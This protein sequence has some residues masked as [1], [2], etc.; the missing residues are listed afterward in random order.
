MG[1]KQVINRLIGFGPRSIGPYANLL[2][3]STYGKPVRRQR[4]IVRN[5][6]FDSDSEWEL[7]VGWSITG[8][9]LNCAA[10]ATGRQTNQTPDNGKVVTGIDYY[11]QF[12]ITAIAS[13]GVSVYFSGTTAVYDDEVG[14]F[15]RT[16]T[17]PSDNAVIS[18]RSLNVG[19]DFSVD[20]VIVRRA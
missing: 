15:T 2:D 7:G 4:N 16:I 3:S 9:T 20:N 12:D 11:F 10:I 19:S 5:G 1:K 6:S 14:T 18:V 13:G 17:A 8:G